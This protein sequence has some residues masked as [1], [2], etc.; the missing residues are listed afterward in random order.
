ME[1][2][3][4]AAEN[5]PQRAIKRT[6]HDA[7]TPGRIVFLPDDTEHSL[8]GVFQ[9]FSQSN[10]AW[11]LCFFHTSL[12]YTLAVFGF[13]FLTEKWSIVDSLYFATTVFTTIGYGDL[14][15]SNHMAMLYTVILATYGV[16][17]LGIFLGIV[18]ERLEFIFNENG[19]RNIL[20]KVALLA[21]AYYSLLRS[22]YSHPL[23][24][25]SD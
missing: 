1:T 4:T 9:S 7:T 23:T 16:V 21:C 11:T 25:C 17:L 14:H 10:S 8:T 2:A 18:G 12:Y 22:P 15:P 13:S 20:Q 6:S 19:G 24:K 5:G 3:S